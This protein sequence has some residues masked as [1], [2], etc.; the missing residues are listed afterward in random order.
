LYP[1]TTLLL[2]EKRR[3]VS[4]QEFS[5]AEVG[6]NTSG[7]SPCGMKAQASQA[8]F[9]TRRSD[10]N[11]RGFCIQPSDSALEF[12]RD[13]FAGAQCLS[14]AN[15]VFDCNPAILRVGRPC[16]RKEE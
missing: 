5:R 12:G 7:F 15:P 14:S 10:L 16:K 4:G 3:F 2:A 1:G 8:I 13:M 11:L 6:H 9:E